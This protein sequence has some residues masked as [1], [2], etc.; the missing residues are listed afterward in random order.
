MKSVPAT[1]SNAIRQSYNLYCKPRLVAEWNMNRYA[2]PI[3]DNIPNESDYGFDIEQFPI[4]SVFEANRPTRGV[5]K[6]RVG[7]SY[8]SDYSEQPDSARYY[9]SSV[10]DTYK[11]WTSP[12]PTSGTTFPSYNQAFADAYELTDSGDGLTVVRPYITYSKAVLANKIVITVENSYSSPASYQILA[13][14]SV[15][16]SFSNIGPANPTI[17]SKG[18]IILYHQGSGTWSTT[19]PA[20]GT[21][22][23]LTSVAGVMIRVNSMTVSNSYFNLIEISARR[24]EDLSDRLISVE[25]TFDTAEKSLIYPIG[26]ITTNSATITLSNIDSIFDADNS[27]SSYYGIIEPN[28]RFTLFYVY[29]ING[30]PYV[31]QDFELYGGPWSGQ[32]DETV[33]ISCEDF[34]KYFQEMTPAPT[35]YQNM[36]VS[37]LVWRLCDQV[38][39]VKYSVALEPNNSQP[40][41]K[42][43]WADGEQ[44]IWEIFDELSRAT[45]TAIYFDSYGVLQI[46]PRTKAFDSSASPVWTLRGAVDTTNAPTELPDIASLEQ[47]DEVGT[48]HDTVSYQDTS[49]PYNSRGFPVR[50]EVWQPEENTVLRAAPLVRTIGASDMNL[51]MPPQ[52]A[53]IWPFSG[54]IQVEGEIIEYEG[55]DYVCYPN[56]VETVKTIKSQDEK[57]DL[58]GKTPA[59]RKYQNHY[60]GRI[61]IK[62][63]GAWNSEAKAHYVD[64][65]GYTVSS[66]VNGTRYVGVGGLSQTRQESV[67]TLRSYNRIDEPRDYLIAARGNQSDTGFVYYGTRMRFNAGYPTQ[68]AGIFFNGKTPSEDGYYIEL[69]ATRTVSPQ[70]ATRNEVSF[71][72]RVGGVEKYLGSRPTAIVEGRFVDVD[73]YVYTVGSDHKIKVFINGV[74]YFTATAS[75]SNKLATG[76]RFGMFVRGRTSAS[77]EYLY[78]VNRTDREIPDQSTWYD[79]VRRAFTSSQ[80][81]RE[82]VYTWRATSRRFRKKWRRAQRRWNRMFMDEFGPILHEVRQYDVK[83]DPKPV[84][85]SRLFISNNQIF[86]P[87]YISDSF[88]AR[89]VLVNGSRKNAILSG[90]DATAG[91]AGNQVCFVYGQVANISEEETVIAKN[92]AQIAARG[93]IES[94]I[95]SQW[96]QS[97]D[98]AQAIASWI[99]KHWSTG[100][101]E[102]TVTIFGNPLIEVT[103]VVSVYYP[104]RN[105]YPSSHKYFVTSISQNFD[106]GLETTIT[107]R[108][109]T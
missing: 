21:T 17:N 31:V 97:K 79:K 65:N 40:L 29:T 16:G 28:V 92:D 83:F 62:E 101:D 67:A 68:R 75:G 25:S 66:I 32:K 38:G 95:T 44:N 89:F 23:P 6:A 10:D 36:S 53:Q 24:E 12:V 41:I 43:F 26:T 56:G 105:M 8:I 3:A 52:D 108:R 106:R 60:N 45:Q 37:E 58:D 48:N 39:F 99:E 18:E 64:I 15:G 47:N 69:Q 85:S 61:R 9:V 78:A 74:L 33:N 19:V 59:A 63:R 96:I 100:A 104:D 34:S 91:N 55:K 90:D 49:F 46:K 77:F 30:T 1:L 73:A 4:E 109:V 2:S 94:E 22:A 35:F 50:E 76:G 27:G 70:R 84:L 102:Q 93:K 80:W 42:H 82:H 98:T 14:T 88:G 87:E 81:D 54:Y 7:E 86:C 72:S 13:K 51:V 57:N 107:L 5:N 71:F 103:D 11:Y 20:A